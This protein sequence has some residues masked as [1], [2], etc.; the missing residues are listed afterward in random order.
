MLALIIMKTTTILIVSIILFIVSIPQLIAQNDIILKID[1]QEMIGKVMEVSPDNIKFV[2]KNETVEYVVPKKEIVKIT[3]ASGRIEFMDGTQSPAKSNSQIAGIT[4]DHHNKVAIL[5]FVYIKNQGDG[6]NGM[7]QKIQSETYSI[8]NK[9]KINLQFQDPTTTNALL[10]KAGI[11]ANTPSTYTMGEICNILG[12][13]YVVQ[14]TVSVEKSGDYNYSNTDVKAKK[15]DTKKDGGLIGQILTGSTSTSSSSSETFS[16]SLNMNVYN[17]K[18]DNIFNQDH[19]AFWYTEDAY[20]T[21]L[22][23]LAKKTPIYMK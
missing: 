2:Y 20:K 14:G 9:K 11:T 13:E 15:S 22:N 16:T 8:Y 12:V 5:P 6:S 19:S 10:A 23:F 7:S 17:D 1:G 21:T 3:F 4:A 18:G